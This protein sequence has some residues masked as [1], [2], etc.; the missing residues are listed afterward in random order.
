MLP[1]SI[2]PVAADES[3]NDGQCGLSCGEVVDLTDR[4]YVLVCFQ[5]E[6]EWRSVCNHGLVE[7]VVQCNEAEPMPRLEYFRKNMPVELHFGCL[8]SITFEALSCKSDL[9]GGKN[10]RRIVSI[11][12]RWK[13]DCPK[14]CNWEGDAAADNEQP[15]PPRKASNSI[16]IRVTS[17]LEVARKHLDMSAKVPSGS[18]NSVLCLP[19]QGALQCR[20]NSVAGRS[21]FSCT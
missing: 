9:V 10:P 7:D 20:T 13:D 1:S 5:V 8:C 18:V 16:E 17:R 3:S 2:S 6:V 14:D 21:R 15:S 19:C 11:R 4:V 12:S